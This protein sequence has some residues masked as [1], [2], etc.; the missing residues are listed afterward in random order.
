MVVHYHVQDHV[1]VQALKGLVW[2]HGST[3]IPRVGLVRRVIYTTGAYRF[4]HA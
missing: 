3:Q 1:H 4:R 2:P